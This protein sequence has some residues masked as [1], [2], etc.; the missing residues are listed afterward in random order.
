MSSGKGLRLLSF[1]SVVEFG[2]TTGAGGVWN[3]LRF[4]FK[5]VFDFNLSSFDSFAIE[6]FDFCN[7]DDEF[8]FGSVDADLTIESR[9][10]E[11]NNLSNHSSFTMNVARLVFGADAQISILSQNK[12]KDENF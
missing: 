4:F 11:E 6:F 3:A 9:L 8:L 7:A 5:R 1:D 12:V 10:K 2:D